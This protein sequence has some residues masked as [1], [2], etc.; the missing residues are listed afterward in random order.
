M[1]NII[2]QKYSRLIKNS[3]KITLTQMQTNMITLTYHTKLWSFLRLL[4]K[5]VHIPSQNPTQVRSFCW[6][7]DV[8]EGRRKSKQGDCLIPTPG[9]H[10]PCWTDKNTR[11]ET[12]LWRFALFATLKKMGQ[13]ESRC[14]S[15]SLRKR[16]CKHEPNHRSFEKSHKPWRWSFV[17]CFSPMG[18]CCE[19]D[20]FCEHFLW[21]LI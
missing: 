11:Q 13:R 19:K 5:G 6:D 9:E 16:I 8:Q 17:L 20:R 10:F 12:A 15:L 2:E 21:R 1:K 3:P 7:Q 14:F 4:F 18:R